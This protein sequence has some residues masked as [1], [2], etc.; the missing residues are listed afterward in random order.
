MISNSEREEIKK[1][2]K[3]VRDKIA[4]AAQKSG[5]KPEDIN[6]V[7]VGKEQP[8]EKLK[9]VRDLGVYALAESRAQELMDKQEKWSEEVDW[10]FVGHLQR[11]KVKYLARMEN[12]KLIHSLDSLRL[13]KEINKRA[14]KNNRIMSVLIQVNVARDENKFGFMPEELI[15][16]LQEAENLENISMEGLMTLVPYYEDSEKARPYFQKLVQLQAEAENKGFDLPELSMGM[17]NDFEVAI[18]EGAT[19]IRLGRGIFGS[20]N[21]N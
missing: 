5:R 10:H 12:C 14:A 16:F 17:T 21:Y 20:R 11:N 7:A 1:R 3:L 15:S 13:A 8:L 19:M 9:L 2:Y 4:D 6:L 18:E